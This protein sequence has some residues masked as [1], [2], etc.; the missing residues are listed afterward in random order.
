[1]LHWDILEHQNSFGIF[2][3]FGH[4]SLTKIVLDGAVVL[5]KVVQVGINVQGGY[6]NQL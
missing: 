2:L 3:F 6:L 1:M 4:F 5:L